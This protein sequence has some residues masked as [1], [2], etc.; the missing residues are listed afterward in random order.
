MAD[1]LKILF[2]QHELYKW[3][4]AKMWGYTWHLGLEEGLRANDVDLFTLMTPWIPR[5]KELCAGRKFD[6]V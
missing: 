1:K 4:R 5:A 2:V 6:Q 3:Q